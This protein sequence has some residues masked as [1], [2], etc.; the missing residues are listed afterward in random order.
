MWNC[1]AYFN[2]CVNPIIYNRTSKEFRDAFMEVCGC[3]RRERSNSADVADGRRV[4]LVT[5]LTPDKRRHLSCTATYFPT[6]SEAVSPSAMQKSATASDHLSATS[7]NC[8]TTLQLSE[9]HKANL[10]V[11]PTTSQHN[12]NVA[13]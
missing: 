13:Q 9:T 12:Q 7:P 8:A 6:P 4:T 2:S 10:L 1:L 11:V 3:R 5:H